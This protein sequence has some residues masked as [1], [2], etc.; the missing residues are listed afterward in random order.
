MMETAADEAAM[1]E[2]ADSARAK[3]TRSS[4]RTAGRIPRCRLSRSAIDRCTAKNVSRR[5]AKSA[6]IREEAFAAANR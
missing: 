2:E 3:S 6:A 1:A 4:A 5:C